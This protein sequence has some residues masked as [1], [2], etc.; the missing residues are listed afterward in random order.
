MSKRKVVDVLPVA[1]DDATFSA[2]QSIEHFPIGMAVFDA[3]YRLAAWNSAYAET[4]RPPAEILRV[5]VPMR[6]MLLKLA[7]RGV[8]GPGEA[9]ELAQTRFDELR[10]GADQREYVY[11]DGRIVEVRTTAPP[12]GGLFVAC[13]DVTAKRQAETSLR[14][15]EQRL[16]D[17]ADTAGDWLWEMGPDLRFTYMSERVADFTGKPAAWHIGKTRTMVSDPERDEAAWRQHFEDLEQ[18]RP[19]RDFQ[20]F[21]RDDNGRKQW[22]NTNGKPR[23]DGDGNFLGYRGAASDITA[24]K[25][26]EIRVKEL[27]AIVA[28]TDDSIFSVSRDGTIASWNPACERLYGYTAEE[29]IGQRGRLLSGDEE[30]AQSQQAFWQQVLRGEPVEQVEVTR[31]HKDGRPLTIALTLSPILDDVGEIV[32]ASGIGRDI[33]EQKRAET[34]IADQRD[35]LQRMNQQKNRLFSIIAHDLRTPFN[36]L[37]G[38]SEI[39]A[40]HSDNLE[41]KEV[42][43]YARMVH[44]SAQQA[45]ELLENLLEWARLQMGRRTSEPRPLDV[46]AAINAALNLAGANAAQK[47]IALERGDIAVLTAFA[48]PAMV[49]TVLRNLVA[50]AVK[51]TDAGGSVTVS[52]QRREKTIAITVSDTG[53]GIAN[54][55]LAGLF[56]M[57]TATSTIGTAGEKGT[58]LGLHLCK[59][60]MELQGGDIEA[61]STPGQGSTFRV[62]LPSAI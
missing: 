52:A 29:A 62:T 46:T 10:G 36:S 4:T 21:R 23:F 35:E 40:S 48:D 55:R 54:D 57:S 13:I 60:L 17:F 49:E 45:H 56:D 34:S 32:G 3:D 33:T 22:F 5:G 38:F 2:G 14:E 16:R 31:T 20:F 9:E 11:P 61:E 15:S 28:S 50:N 51:F 42:G 58:G 47:E 44:E 1:G 26:A 8:L 30:Q 27:A 12:G 39:L 24:R 53:I 19:F 41:R 25:N 7:E 37:L 59:D 18:R 6:E 43:D